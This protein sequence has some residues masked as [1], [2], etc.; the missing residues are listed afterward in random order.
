MCLIPTLIRRNSTGKPRHFLPSRPPHTRLTSHPQT[1]LRADFARPT[2]PRRAS[3]T[4]CVR[5]TLHAPATPSRTTG[6]ATTA[7]AVSPTS[8][9]RHRPLPP[10]TPATGRTR[11]LWQAPPTHTTSLRTCPADAPCTQTDG[12]PLS[13]R[14]RP[15]AKSPKK[16]SALSAATSSR[17][18]APT[19]T[20]QP[21]RSTCRNASRCTR[22]R[23]LPFLRP[24]L[25]VT[26][27]IHPPVCPASGHVA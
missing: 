8:F 21:A 25:A 17:P 2:D 9:P 20:T 19:A 16:T 12:S 10:T 11:A 22:A 4:A 24:H 1:H 26:T 27:R 23:R 6:P 7:Q 14:P 15:A 3:A 18:K 5:A 13:R